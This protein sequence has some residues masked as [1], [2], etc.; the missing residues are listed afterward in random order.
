MGADGNRM[1]YSRNSS[2]LLEAAQATGSRQ[3]VLITWASR[4]SGD[5][6]QRP[7]H[8]MQNRE[9]IAYYKKLPNV[10]TKENKTTR[11]QRTGVRPGD[12][13]NG[14]SPTPQVDVALATVTE[15]E[16]VQDQAVQSQRASVDTVRL[17][18]HGTGR[19]QQWRAVRHQRLSQAA[20]RVA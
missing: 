16:A 7:V 10:Y 14:R 18:R 9:S 20:E 3:A 11:Q 1:D 13:T 15:S 19:S 6:A 5:G 8:V 4:G 2:A 17:V 12:S